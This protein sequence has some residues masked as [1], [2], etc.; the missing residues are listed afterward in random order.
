MASPV[1]S[2]SKLGFPWQTDD[3]FLFCVYHND[4]FP[5]GQA[6][7]SPAVANLWRGRNK[8]ADF[9][10]KDWNMYHGEKIPGFPRHPHR[11]FETVTVVR[12]G[13]VDHADGVGC[14]GRFGDGDVQW[15]TAGK[16]ITHSEMF[17]LLNMEGT[18]RLEL[19]QIWLNLPAR[20]KMADP[21]FQMLWAETLPHTQYK[22]AAGKAT[23][24]CTISGS[25]AEATTATPAPPPASWAS[26]PDSELAIW[27]IDLDAGATWTLPP[28]AGGA[29][30]ARTLYFFRGGE[31]SALTVGGKQLHGHSAVGLDAAAAVE[32]SAGA[33]GGCECL[34]LQGRPIGE[35]VVQHGPFVMT[36]KQEI[37][38]AF[39]DY[40]RTEF[41]G[42][43]GWV[44]STPS[45][46]EDHAPAWAR[47]TG[48]F[49]K[50]ADGRVESP[51]GGGG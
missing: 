42:P 50:Y 12:H 30:I 14:S 32:L 44:H 26:E 37:M 34:L 24:V 22:D 6:D 7:M 1:R 20:N 43:A 4:V 13:K 23:R 18:N 25:V 31:T 5:P 49:A 36:S 8:G 15:M 28:A 40:Q 41:Q 45:G 27:T 10:S 29:A 21:H 2:V 3:P 46:G 9:G 11:G 19:F 47:E 16:G 48:R 51:P 38:Q 17:P 39:E 35:P 33:A